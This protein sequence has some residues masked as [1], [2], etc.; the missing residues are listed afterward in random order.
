MGR[1]IQLRLPFAGLN[2]GHK[3]R[4]RSCTTR[5]VLYYVRELIL[6][7]ASMHPEFNLRPSCD[8]LNPD[9]RLI[10][11]YFPRYYIHKT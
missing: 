9:I 3:P 1:F 10:T 11:L 7:S 5:L 4:P 8:S 6:K 2:S